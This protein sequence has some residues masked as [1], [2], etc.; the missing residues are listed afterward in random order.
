M[1]GGWDGDLDQFGEDIDILEE[2]IKV[3]IY[4]D[5]GAGKTRL[6]GGLPNAFHLS[7]ERGVIAAKAAPKRGIRRARHVRNWDDLVQGY[8]DLRDNEH[9]FQNIVVESQ[10]D[11]QEKLHFRLMERNAQ[12]NPK[13]NPDKLSQSGYLE[14]QNKIKNLINEFNELPANIWWSAQSMPSMTPEGEEETLPFITSKDDKLARVVCGKMRGV[15][16]LK[17][18]R[19]EDDKPARRLIINH[20]GYHFAKDQYGILPDYIDRPD[21]MEITNT[22]EAATRRPQPAVRRTAARRRTTPARRS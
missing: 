11:L 9:P 17:V 19:D 15:W 13:E 5:S 7:S 1:S 4:G 16:Y 12:L 2:P 14:A 22:I 3:L 21:L 10:T 20:D 6:L 8:R 18:V